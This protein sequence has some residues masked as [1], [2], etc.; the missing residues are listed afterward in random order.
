MVAKW[1]KEHFKDAESARTTIS[2][3]SGVLSLLAFLV[4]LTAYLSI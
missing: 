3:A 4:V 1:L 2:V